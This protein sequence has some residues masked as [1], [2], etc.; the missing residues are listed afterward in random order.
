MNVPVWAWI[1]VVGFILAVLAVDLFVL[2]RRAEVV[3]GG[4]AALESALWVTIGLGFGAII[5]I[6]AGG[7]RGGQYFAGYLT[8]K[9]LSIDNLFLFAAIFGAFAVPAAYQHRVLFWGVIG[10]LGT[11]ALFVGLGGALLANF[12]W[13]I[14]AFGLLLLFMAARMFLRRPGSSDPNRLW[15][16]RVVRRVVPITSNLHGPRFVVRDAGASR[17]RWAVTPLL[18]A[19][20]AVEGTDVLF[21]L[22]SVP[23]V[24]GVT[25]DP[26]LVFTSNAFAIV[27]LRAMYFLLADAVG[28][29][30]YLRH[31][32]AAILAFVGAKMLASPVYELPVW[33]S[34]TVI[35]TLLT[36]TCAA[37]TWRSRTAPSS[38][39]RAA[40]GEG[41][42]EAGSFS[43]GARHPY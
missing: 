4:K 42:D 9:A 34:L 23:A 40:A 14:E 31:G 36:A 28:R 32:L 37:S 11:R 25:R 30:V 21:A 16:L 1:A 17:R 7:E 22:D 20:V 10:A 6:F 35:A 29:L 8:E 24:F 5:W 3:T 39:P 18:I 19:L 13:A 15:S 2:H 26:F 12:S 33:V 27:G 38:P 43:G 41:H